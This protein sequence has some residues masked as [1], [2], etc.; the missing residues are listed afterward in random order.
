MEILDSAWEEEESCLPIP[1]LD[2]GAFSPYHPTT[3]ALFQFFDEIDEN[4][5]VRDDTGTSRGGREEQKTQCRGK[6]MKRLI[7]VL[8]PEEP[9]SEPEGHSK[10]CSDPIADDQK[11]CI[12]STP[13]EGNEKGSFNQEAVDE[14]NEINNHAIEG[15]KSILN[16]SMAALESK[17]ESTKRKLHESYKN[18]E[19]AK[20]KRRIQVIE[21]QPQLMPK[22]VACHKLRR[23]TSKKCNSRLISQH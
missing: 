21:F 3:L 16:K 6:E 8:K 1:P 12:D 2:D 23:P 17:F 7:E 20:K 15:D 10:P 22:Q 18:I 5:N 11:A 13:A 9:L 19:N 14:K 4:G